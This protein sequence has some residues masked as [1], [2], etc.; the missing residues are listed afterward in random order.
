VKEHQLLS[1]GVN[2]SLYS[3]DYDRHHCMNIHISPEHGVNFDFFQ[4]RSEAR[5]LPTEGVNHREIWLEYHNPDFVTFVTPVALS[6]CTEGTLFARFRKARVTDAP[7]YL[8]SFRLP[9]SSDE[10]WRSDSFFARVYKQARQQ[11]IRPTLTD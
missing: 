4:A 9:G 7:S 11:F 6:G 2:T 10:S 8:V 3:F 1:S 5:E